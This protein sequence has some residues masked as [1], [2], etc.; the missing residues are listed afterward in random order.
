MIR[1]LLSPVLVLALAVATGCGRA[2]RGSVRFEALCFPP[3]PDA[4]GNCPFTSGTCDAVLADGHLFVDLTTSGETKC[5]APL[6]DPTQCMTLEYPIQID[7]LRPNNSDNTVGRTNTNNAFIDRFD[8][9]YEAP[10][11]A[12]L[13]ASVNQS[14]MVPAAGSTVAVVT[15]IPASAGKA[16]ADAL[17]AGPTEG[18]IHVKA[19]GRYGDDTEFDTAEFSV[20]V[21]VSQGVIG[22]F[23]CADTTKKLAGV[24]PQQ[25]QT[26][27]ALC[28]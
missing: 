28:Q 18:V 5:P 25:G 1:R 21:A 24:C 14:V 12:T 7:N 11:F 16:I 17:P 23:A 6:L 22:P 26:A 19:H 13:S 9:R 20:P 10:G 4:N 3:T 15:L 2:D 8:M 27:V